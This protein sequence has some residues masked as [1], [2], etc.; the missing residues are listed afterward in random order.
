MSSDAV[1]KNHA[2]A[3]LIIPFH[4]SPMAA[5]GTSSRQ[6]RNQEVSRNSLDISSNSALTEREEA[7]IEKV[8]F[9]AIAVKIAKIDAASSP[10]SEPGKRARK[11]VTVIERKPS[12]GT[13][14]RMSSAG[15]IRRSALRLRAAQ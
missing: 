4:T 8:I 9:Q 2:P 5:L 6:K 3:I 15:T 12:T 14:C 1:R 10:S 11:P 13:D 7:Y